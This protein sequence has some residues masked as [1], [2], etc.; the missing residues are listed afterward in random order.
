MAATPCRWRCLCR[1]HPA[2]C[3]CGRWATR[4]APW[5]SSSVVKTCSSGSPP[6]PSAAVHCWCAS[7][8]SWSELWPPGQNRKRW[9]EV[10]QTEWRVGRSGVSRVQNSSWSSYLCSEYPELNNALVFL[11]SHSLRGQLQS[12]NQVDFPS[13]LNLWIFSVKFHLAKKKKKTSVNV[14]FYLNSCQN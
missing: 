10:T 11:L 6:A 3:T 13:F 12:T 1:S 14:Q 5:S 7:S 4:S 8:S 2:L 9:G